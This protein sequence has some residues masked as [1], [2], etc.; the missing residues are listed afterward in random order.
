MQIMWGKRSMLNGIPYDISGK[1]APQT[2]NVRAD[3]KS[4]TLLNIN[5]IPIVLHNYMLLMVRI[6]ISETLTTMHIDTL[7]LENIIMC[8]DFNFIVN[9][10][11]DCL[12]RHSN[13]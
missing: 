8:G 2:Q 9:N 6:Y 1:S 12:M 10:S 7:E 5:S 13:N 4:L 11:L 3:K